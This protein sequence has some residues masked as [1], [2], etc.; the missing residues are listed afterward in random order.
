MT[1]E[2][3]IDRFYWELTPGKSYFPWRLRL[4]MALGWNPTFVIFQPIDDEKYLKGAAA[5]G[6]VYL[7]P[8]EWVM[9]VTCRAWWMHLVMGVGEPHSHVDGWRQW[10]RKRVYGMTVQSFAVKARI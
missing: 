5:Y 1:E 6:G 4:R 7:M 3:K 2:E 9:N 10:N 8:P